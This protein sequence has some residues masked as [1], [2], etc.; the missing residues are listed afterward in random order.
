[1]GRFR[2]GP[3]SGGFWA[4]LCTFVCVWGS[5]CAVR[6]LGREW[7][8]IHANIGVKLPGSLAGGV[9]WG[10]WGFLV[11]CLGSEWTRM[12]GV[13]LWG[14]AQGS[15]LRR[16]P[17]C[18]GRIPDLSGG[19]GSSVCTSCRCRRGRW[20]YGRFSGWLG[21]W[22]QLDADSP[23]FLMGERARVP[24]SQVRVVSRIVQFC[25]GLAGSAGLR[26]G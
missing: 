15:W 21:F 9:F 5:S 17:P 13:K 6:G 20:R 8:R 2:L 1:M 14:A 12:N 24:D 19:S 7:T 18:A 10:F 22:P 16:T 25:A 11:H 23:E 3:V 26:P 4:F